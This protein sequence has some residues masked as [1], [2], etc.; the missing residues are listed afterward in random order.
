MKM[1]KHQDLKKLMRQRSVIKTQRLI[2][3]G[4]RPVIAPIA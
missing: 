4:F 1:P 2:V 3:S